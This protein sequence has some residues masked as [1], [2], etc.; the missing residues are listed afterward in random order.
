MAL[1]LNDPKSILKLLHSL[2]RHSGQNY[3][4]D[5]KRILAQLTETI[6]YPAS[7]S[8]LSITTSSASF[9]ISYAV[10][11]TNLLQ[12]L[13]SLQSL[14]PS[15]KPNYS[16]IANKLLSLL[17]LLLTSH[18]D[19]ESEFV[20]FISRCINYE[21]L[22]HPDLDINDTQQ[23]V[24]FLDSLVENDSMFNTKP[25]EVSLLL[26]CNDSDFQSIY[27]TFLQIILHKKSNEFDNGGI[28]SGFEAD[29]EKGFMEEGFD[30]ADFGL[31]ELISLRGKKLESEDLSADFNK[32]A[33][34]LIDVFKKH[35]TIDYF[36]LNG[37]SL[38]NKIH[39]S[40]I[41]FFVGGE[42]PIL[43][44]RFE[45][46]NRR[47]LSNVNASQTTQEFI[48][49]TFSG[50]TNG[51][52]YN[53]ARGQ[54]VLNGCVTHVLDD[55]HNGSFLDLNISYQPEDLTHFSN[56][57]KHPCSREDR[58]KLFY[59]LQYIIPHLNE[60]HQDLDPKF[61]Y[62][63]NMFLKLVYETLPTIST[64]NDLMFVN[65]LFTNVN[66]IVDFENEDE[67]TSI[68]IDITAENFYNLHLKLSESKHPH[69]T[70]LM[71]YANLQFR[72][73][74]KIKKNYVACWKNQ[75][76]E[77]SQL[78]D[79]LD[80]W[81]TKKEL[82]QQKSILTKWFSL[83]QKSLLI[84]QETVNFYNLRLLYKVMIQKWRSRLSMLR[85]RLAILQKSNS[86]K[87]LSI[88]RRKLKNVYGVQN[89]SDNFNDNRLKAYYFHRLRDMHSKNLNLD[90]TAIEYDQ[91][92]LLKQK[93]FITEYYFNSWANTMNYEILGLTLGSQTSH[94][95][96]NWGEKAKQLNE[97]LYHFVTRKHFSVWLR[98]KVLHEQLYKSQIY[99]DK[100]ILAYTFSDIWIKKF[101]L[102]ATAEKN[103]AMNDLRRKANIFKLWH[104][105]V[106]KHK[107]AEDFHYHSIMKDCT[108]VWR[109][110]H[111]EIM[112]TKKFQKN[113]PDQKEILKNTLNR[114]S[115]SA[116]VRAFTRRRDQGYVRSSLNLWTDKSRV[117]REMDTRADLFIE[118]HGV[119]DQLNI[120]IHRT[121]K[122][123]EMKLIS[124]MKV[125]RKFLNRFINSRNKC[126][127]L[128]GFSKNLSTKRTFAD[129]FS[130]KLMFKVW[131]KRHEQ[132]FEKTSELKIQHMNDNLVNPNL[133]AVHLKLWVEKY[134]STQLMKSDLDRMSDLFQRSSRVVKFAFTS[135]RK[136]KVNSNQRL[137]DAD[138]FQEVI[139]SKK[140]MVIWYNQCYGKLNHL[141]EI[142]ETINARKEINLLEEVI[143]NWSR[144]VVTTFKRNQ[145]SCDLFISRWQV[146]KSKGI[147]NLWLVKL[148][149]R[150]NEVDEFTEDFSNLSTLSPLAQRRNNK[151]TRENTH[152]DRSYLY[153]PI[154]EQFGI[155][156]TNTP[157]STRGSPSKLQETTQR[158]KYERINALRQYLKKAKV[159]QVSTPQRR[160]ALPRDTVQTPSQ[161]TS[162]LQSNNTI[163]PPQYRGI[164]PPA[165]PDF[166]SAQNNSTPSSES[167]S[168][169]IRDTDL[170]TA[171]IDSA[172]KLRRITPIRF[173]TEEDLSQPTFSPV[174][175]LKERMRRNLQYTEQSQDKIT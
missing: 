120:W 174:N 173:P 132:E 137:A 105:I 103:L 95:D 143:H 166:S 59:T 68:D 170:E 108:R 27:D 64:P 94:I 154:K 172:K 140:Y 123:E 152:E 90:Q 79:R 164:T 124:D 52:N 165:P 107:V 161:S 18:A 11:S 7:T 57:G 35:R 19:S 65:D 84:D 156:S 160:A 112:A 1:R 16:V 2:Q 29:F 39:D 114:I 37:Q 91:N 69:S 14:L 151:Y 92:R 15:L 43:L 89:Q 168:T 5:L 139:L 149:E 77:N 142:F 175:K 34:V 20:S 61:P 70:L 63:L 98:S 28:N 50:Q 4:L 101:N 82:T 32:Y 3:E 141:D 21:L 51:N 42:N 147:L 58:I 33:R 9:D 126:K 146:L 36:E 138:H 115:S 86:N 130:Q 134:N 24:N 26:Q 78:L 72:S 48:A 150:M 23:I 113:N 125:Q 127:K 155:A 119:K 31:K 169:T 102:I 110:R 153:T 163:L 76:L 62:I 167:S 148:R 80:N 158:L 109:L 128:E 159:H 54:S 67:H 97:R 75:V 136:A 145:E 44:P 40:F 12:Y 106:E 99:N 53:A 85:G 96:V 45:E 6:N 144:K 55:H 171:T 71:R 162:L 118:L 74:Y 46:I 66:T 111:L 56:E 38:K 17:S 47:A 93:T 129:S 116:K 133:I 22:H 135:W 83:N 13:H 157:R 8:T 60:F 81:Q 88:W 73:N 100:T 104:D 25:K 10:G 30:K 122:Y 49:S 117:T 41:Q 87:F 131:T 121:M